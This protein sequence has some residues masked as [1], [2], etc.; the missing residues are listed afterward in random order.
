MVLPVRRRQ[1][2]FRYL[3]KSSKS[4]KPS[5]IGKKVT[6][7]RYIKNVVKSQSETK[8]KSETVLNGVSFNSKITTSNEMYN[9]IPSLSLGDNSYN[10]D[11]TVVRPTHIKLNF[12]VYWDNGAYNNQP[13]K[14]VELFILKDKIQRNGNYV[15]TTTNILK[16][17]TNDTAVQYDGTFIRSFM[18]VDTTNFE[19]IKRKKLRLGIQPY[20]GNTWSTVGDSTQPMWRDYSMKIPVKKFAKIFYYNDTGNKP[21]NCNIFCCIGYVK[22]DASV[23]GDGVDLTTGIKATCLSTLYFKDI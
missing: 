14:C 12:R 1:G 17:N 20:S 6:L 11:G 3:K 4:F 9:V 22:A 16:D 23:D 19:V 5:I 21:V 2:R 8:C 13:P 7:K 15:P 18:P 10:R